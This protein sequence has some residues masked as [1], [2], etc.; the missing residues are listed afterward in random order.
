MTEYAAKY[1]LK[2]RLEKPKLAEWEQRQPS[3]CLSVL[4]TIALQVSLQKDSS[5]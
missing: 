1:A 2:A 4:K 3:N 5:F